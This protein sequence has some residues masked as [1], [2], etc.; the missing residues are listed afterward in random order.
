MA[1]PTFFQLI[2]CGPDSGPTHSSGRRLIKITVRLIAQR[3]IIPMPT[4]VLDI[5]D[6]NDDLLCCR[7]RRARPDES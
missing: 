6:S 2:G 1:P 3:P 7:S 4:T 5:M